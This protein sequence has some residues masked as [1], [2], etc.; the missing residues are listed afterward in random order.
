MD[1]T[2]LKEQVLRRTTFINACLACKSL[3]R[4]VRPIYYRTSDLSCGSEHAS[5]RLDGPFHVL[6]RSQDTASLVLRLRMPISSQGRAEDCT[7]IPPNASDF[8][9][10]K[11]LRRVAETAR[12]RKS[13]RLALLESIKGLRAGAVCGAIL[14]ACVNLQVLHL[15]TKGSHETM[16]TALLDLV[17]RV[18]SESFQKLNELVIEHKP[19]PHLLA[20]HEIP[21]VLA[22]PKLK[23]FRGYQ[24]AFSHRSGA[25][26]LCSMGQVAVEQ[27]ELYNSWIHR[28]G[29]ESLLRMCPRLKHLTII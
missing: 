20:L 19:D 14:F 12:L 6:L 1:Y 9:A 26:P 18:R 23:T 4:I 17:G 22:L 29:M 3:Y 24:V 10:I 16:P 11:S 28:V 25:N 8:E 7:F 27:I 2:S 21:H 5:A 13:T 15:R